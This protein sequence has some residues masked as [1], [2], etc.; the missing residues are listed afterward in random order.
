MAVLLKPLTDAEPEVAARISR[1]VADRM[2]AAGAPVED[3]RVHTAVRAGVAMFVSYALEDERALRPGDEAALRSMAR[4]AYRRGAALADVLGAVR[5]GVQT[6]SDAVFWEAERLLPHAGAHVLMGKLVRLLMAFADEVSAVVADA[7]EQHAGA[8]A[9]AT[10]VTPEEAL[11]AILNGLAEEADAHFAFPQPHWLVLAA[12]PSP[13]VVEA[14]DASGA[15][16]WLAP[17]DGPFVAL[18]TDDPAG[19]SAISRQA[20]I[21]AARLDGTTVLATDAA[22]SARA[23]RD[24]YQRAVHLLPHVAAAAPGQAVVQLC[25]LADYELLASA[26]PERADALVDQVLGPVLALRPGRSAVLLRTLAAILDDSP[27]AAAA[28]L[29]LNAKTVYRHLAEI[30]RLTGLSPVGSGTDV[31]RLGLGL[32]MLRLRQA[33]SAERAA[34]TPGRSDVHMTDIGGSEVSTRGPSTAMGRTSTVRTGAD[35][36]PGPAVS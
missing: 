24:A 36:V 13:G 1:V 21:A 17:L 12:A 9:R 4:L 6:M 2:V 18:V 19:A 7:Y 28:R 15:L 10:A 11:T 26:S 23:V 5:V 20:F 32:R 34:A 3:E 14:V 29:G 22:T 8:R 30:T 25:S 16:A 33:A 27:K 35:S 31:Y